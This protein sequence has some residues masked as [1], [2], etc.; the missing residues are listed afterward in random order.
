MTAESADA[1]LF[2]ST[3]RSRSRGTAAIAVSVWSVLSSMC[4]VCAARNDIAAVS[5]S[6][7]SPTMI[8]SGSWRRN[9]RR[10]EANVFPMSAF[11]SDWLNCS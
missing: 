9:A 10:Y 4:P 7:I 2:G 11:T 6:R 3:R 5:S 1:M 8:T